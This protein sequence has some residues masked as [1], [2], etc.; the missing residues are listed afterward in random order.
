M[1]IS[2]WL[3]NA[4]ALAI[5]CAITACPLFPTALFGRDAREQQRIDYLI[6]S[7]GSLK[8]TVFIRNGSEYDAQ[9]ARDHLQR[10]LNFAGGRVKTAEEFIK[11]CATESSISH[12]PY[13]IRFADGTLVETA[14]YFREK[15]K[16]F[17]QRKR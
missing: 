2:E 13:K 6:Q 15:L 3:E 16:E 8:G 10:K 7:L 17:D 1:R 9:A 11:Y 14:S 4:I 5:L 12:Q